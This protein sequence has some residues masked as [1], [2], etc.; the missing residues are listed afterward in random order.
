M[1]EPI[2]WFPDA[3]AR[4]I[5]LLK[6]NSWNESVRLL[7][8]EIEEVKKMVKEVKMNHFNGVT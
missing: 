4:F 3:S 1:T 5:E 2:K 8:R 7:K 6:V